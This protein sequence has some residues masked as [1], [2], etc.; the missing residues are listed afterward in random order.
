MNNA[1]DVNAGKCCLLSQPNPKTTQQQ[2]NLIRLRLDSIITPKPP[3]PPHV[4]GN[5]SA[6]NEHIRKEQ[7]S[8]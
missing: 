3:H 1:V 4:M 6:V 8:I 2:L 5:G 7:E